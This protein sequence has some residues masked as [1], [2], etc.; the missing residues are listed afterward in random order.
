MPICWQ[1]FA[2]DGCERCRSSRTSRASWALPCCKRACARARGAAWLYN[3]PHK[4]ASRS[5]LR[6]L[7]TVRTNLFRCRRER[8]IFLLRR[9]RLVWLGP[10]ACQLR[11][12]RVRLI[13]STQARGFQWLTQCNVLSGQ[14]HGFGPIALIVS[15]VDE[16]ALL[17]SFSI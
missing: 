15:G 12:L 10:S 14:P 11:L 4:D 17:K 16:L 9:G 8:D 1:T 13:M 6:N 3:G 7:A 2:S 5:A